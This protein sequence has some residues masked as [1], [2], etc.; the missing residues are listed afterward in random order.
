MTRKKK[1]RE[2][3]YGKTKSPYKYSEN[4][5]RWRAARLAGRASEAREHALAHARQFGYTLGE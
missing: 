3:S 5:H 2:N 4:Y 1:I